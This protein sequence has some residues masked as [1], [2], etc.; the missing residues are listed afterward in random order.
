[1]NI[2]GAPLKFAIFARITMRPAAGVGKGA[3]GEEAKE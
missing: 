2:M 1:M 3:R